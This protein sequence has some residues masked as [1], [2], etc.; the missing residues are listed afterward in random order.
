MV[1]GYYK[2]M[3]K[4]RGGNKEFIPPN[5]KPGHVLKR[6]EIK[7][8]KGRKTVWEHWETPEVRAALIELHISSAIVADMTGDREQFI[9]SYRYLKSRGVEESA[10][11]DEYVKNRTGEEV[12]H[13]SP[14]GDGEGL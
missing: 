14:V 4:D 13:K 6:H 3:G 10:R 2:G 8:K 12:S 5:I 9:R 11:W 1:I 7:D